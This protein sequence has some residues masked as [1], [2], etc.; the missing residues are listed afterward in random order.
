MRKFFLI[1]SF[2]FLLITSLLFAGQHTVELTTGNDYGM[3]YREDDPNNM[4]LYGI[5]QENIGNPARR[6]LQIGLRNH[7]IYKSYFSY[8]LSG[9]RDDITINSVRV[10]V[11]ME[12]RNY[13]TDRDKTLSGLTNN[14]DPQTMFHDFSHIYNVLEFPTM[15]VT[16][17]SSNDAIVSDIQNSL[18][19]NWFG[20]K[21]EFS[22]DPPE[23]DIYYESK[24]IRVWVTYTI[25]DV[26]ITVNTNPTGM[27]YSFTWKIPGISDTNSG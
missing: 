4:V 10:L 11:E 9:L 15:D 23:N 18:S 5:Y 25:P 17:G 21:L 26:Q 6:D 7:R 14:Y 8:D 3:V 20:L 19:D 1:G 24:K 16:W 22:A 27:Q 13:T 2:I 12:N